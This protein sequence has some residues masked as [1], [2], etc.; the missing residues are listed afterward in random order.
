MNQNICNICGANYEYRN[1]RWI[2]P[3]CGAYKAEEL[4]NEEVTLLYNAAQKLRVQ[5]FDV[6]EE[7]YSDIINKYPKQHEAYWGYVC[8]K[9]GIK[10][11]VDFN[12]RKIPTCCYTTIES[13]IEDTDYKKALKFAPTEIA[14]WYKS[15]ADYIERVRKTWIEKA[16]SEPPYDIFISYK[17]SDIEHGIER[18]EDSYNALEL[19]NHLARQ[20]YNVFYS[21]ESLR[22]K[23]G[24]K[25]EPYIYHALQTAKVMIIYASSVDY[26]NSTWVKNEWHR[27][28][29]QISRGEK[30]EGSLLVVCD[31]FSPNELPTILSSKQ[32]LDGKSK[33]LYIDI[34]DYLKRLYSTK[35]T[36]EKAPA[37]KKKIVVN[38]LHE[39]TYTD[40]V[41]PASCVARGYTVH[42]CACGY[43]YKDS[44]TNLA[45]HKYA[46]KTTKEPTCTTSG[47]TEEVCSVCGDKKVNNIPAK[48]HTFGKW[49]EKTPPTCI[50]PGKK[51][52]QCS[53]C[54]Y[55]EEQE[56]PAKGHQWS[57]T[58]QRL[59]EHGNKEY[60]SFCKL[61]GEE[62]VS[63]ETEEERKAKEAQAQ[64]SKKTL[65]SA[66]GSGITALSFFV[67]MIINFAGGEKIGWGII[68]LLIAFVCGGASVSFTKEFI[69]LRP[70]L[71][72][73]EKTR[74]KKKVTL[75]FIIA[76]TVIVLA[77]I[78][79]I[80]TV[81]NN[82]KTQFEYTKHWNNDYVT[83]KGIKNESY[84]IKNGTVEIPSTIDGMQVGLGSLVFD[85]DSF[86]TLV[87]PK[88]LQEIFSDSLDGCIGL[89]NIVYKGTISDWNNIEGVEDIDISRYNFTHEGSCE[90]SAWNNEPNYDCELGGTKTRSCL[91]CDK[92]YTETIAP[93]THTLTTM[94]KV[95]PTCSSVGKTEG[96]K[97]SSCNKIIVAQNDISKLSHTVVVD[98]AVPATCSETGLT[99]G[100]HCSVCNA[101]LVAQTTIKANGHSYG[102]WQI[103]SQA[104]CTK[105]GTQKRVCSVCSGTDTSSIS[106]KGHSYSN[107][108]CSSCGAKQPSQGLTYVDYGNGYA[109]SGLGNCTDTEIVLPDTHN[110]KPVVAITENAFYE[111]SWITGV[112]IPDTVT[113][114]ERMAFRYCTSIEELRIPDSVSTI[115]AYAFDNCDSISKL[116]LG[117]G[118][119]YV[120]EGG[121]HDCDNILEVHISDI[122][123]YATINYDLFASP[124]YGYRSK[125]QL[126]VNGNLATNLT[127]PGSTGVIGERVFDN[128]RTITNV[129]IEY[130]V[131]TIS[132]YAFAECGGLLTVT[133]PTS[134]KEI[135]FYS[136]S[137]GMSALGNAPKLEKIIY[138]G[139]RAQW[140]QITKN[141]SWD[142]DNYGFIIQCTDGNIE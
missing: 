49:I 59:D 33:N 137:G 30:K 85:G 134:V 57:P 74:R 95:E 50:V 102:S 54:G 142:S 122:Q 25:Y 52:R 45:E 7:L 103:V 98:N 19:Y 86:T 100:T 41:I 111:I 116:Y 69:K 48:G 26:V 6:A 34:D 133:I 18:T 20:G 2:C 67:F 27:Y 107:K 17:D 39:H 87:L 1:G 80:I 73:E 63:K 93:T 139:T 114:I 109:V 11:E 81:R 131:T 108:I 104:T 66:I 94:P 12:G 31:G 60:V 23:V 135:G 71:S 13:F 121:F 83:I 118:L 76:I 97:C 78:I 113:T 37:S 51:I 91:Y 132:D 46:H 96:T 136:F 9:Y 120:A 16:K 125:A 42:R 62:K 115:G 56:L 10:Y 5:E 29:K 70:P 68:F 40:E 127:I 58:E 47:Y 4:S 55:V 35:A 124:F 15:Q 61:C 101:T 32:C 106:A 128:C 3:A 64:L 117:T 138:Q 105:N 36:E 79:T 24:E 140:M 77:V 72:E 84:A 99:E 21:K 82:P 90:C 38:P 123:A 88:N 141:A 43:E 28:I 126:Y 75:F 8:S 110:G 22:D 44:Y 112:I 92:V 53:E 89:K 14:D 130:G 119:T 129:V 65:G